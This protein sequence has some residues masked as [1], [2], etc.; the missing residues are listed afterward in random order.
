MLIDWGSALNLAASSNFA[1]YKD[2]RLPNQKELESIVE[3]KCFGPAINQVVFPKTFW[4]YPT[5]YWSSSPSPSESYAGVYFVSFDDGRSS[6]TGT[7]GTT[8]WVRLVR[9]RQ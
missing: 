8:E 4:S 1:G 7:N 9:G 6:S 2:W 3:N 5:V